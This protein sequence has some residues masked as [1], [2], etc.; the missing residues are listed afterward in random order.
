[1]IQI[2][3]IHRTKIG[4]HIGMLEM[5]FRTSTGAGNCARDKEIRIKH[6]RTELTCDD[7]LTL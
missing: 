5:S 2:G 6:P 4:K 7:S 3:D 1:M